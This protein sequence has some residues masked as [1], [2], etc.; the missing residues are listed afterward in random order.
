[1]ENSYEKDLSI[2]PE[3]LDIEWIR[4]PRLYMKY[5]ELSAQADRAHRKA[6][7]NFDAV[8]AILDSDIRN[9]AAKNETK[10]T[11]GAIRSQT[12]LRKEY[13]EAQEQLNESAYKASIFSAAVK[14]FEHRKKAL[15]GL[16]QLWIGSYF[17][18][19]KQPHD[20]AEI[21][22]MSEDTISRRIRNKLNQSQEE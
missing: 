16:V 19:P 17:S 2:D 20:A 6:K 5:S 4:Q 18:G 3:A 22:R 7:E 11:E 14:A 10:I 9:T 12:L 13:K 15:E 21:K 1:M 8:C